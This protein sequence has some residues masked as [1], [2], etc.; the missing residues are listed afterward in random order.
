MAQEENGIPVGD[1]NVERRSINFLPR[2][3]RTTANAKFIGSTL[4]QMLQPGVVEKVDG[5]VGRK[6]SKAFVSTDNYVK[7]VSNTRQS[8]QLEPAAVVEDNV[9][10]VIMYKDYMDYM[11]STAIRNAKTIDHSITNAQEYYAWDPHINWDKFV[12]FREYYWL[13]QG[14]NPIAVYGNFREVESTITVNAIDN[15][16][17]FG[18]NFNPINP[19]SNTTLTLFRGQTYVFDI[20]TPNMPFTIRTAK[21]LDASSIYSTGVSSQKVDSGQ[22]TFEVDLEAPNYL[23]Y[24]NE[25]DIEASGL[26]IIKDILDNTVI[27]VEQEILNKKAY[28]MANGYNLSNGMKLKFYGDVSPAKYANGNWYVEGVGDSITLV[29]EADVVLTADYLIDNAIEFDGGGFSNLPFDNATSYANQKDYI[30]INKAS[31]DKNQWSRYNR[32][33]HKSVIEQ[34]AKINN[35][36][37]ELDQNFRAVRPIIEFEAGLKLYNC[38]SF[39]KQAVD[40]VD[41]VTKDVFSTIEG[42]AGYFVDQTE[43]VSGMRVLFTADPD[44]FVA[45]KIYEVKFITQN[46]NRQITLVETDD[47]APQENETV[48]VTSGAKF[49]GKLFWYNGTKWNQAQDKIKLN[50]APLFDLY[51]GDDNSLSDL[52][53]SSFVGNKIFSYKEG[54]GSNDTELAFPLSYRTIENSGDIVFDFN[55]LAD[56]YTYDDIANVITAS[57]DIGYLRKYTSRTSYASLSAWTKADKKSEQWVVGQPTVGPRT[58]NF[59]ISWYNKSGNLSDLEVRVY[60]N[61][62]RIKDF[63][64]VRNN[65]TAYVQFTENLQ[66]GSKLVIKTKSKAEKN[67]NGFYEFPI[68]LEKNPQNENVTSFT[69]GE[70]LDHVSSIVDNVNEFEGTYPGSSNLRDIGNLSKNGLRFVKHSGPINLALFNL[71]QKDYDAIK[72]IKYAGI[73]YRKF[74]REFVR[75]AGELGFDGPTKLH[76]DKVLGAVNDGKTSKDAFYFSD[77]VPVGGDKATTHVIDDAS[78]TI[79][80]LTRGIDFTKLN[81]FAVLPYLNG[82]V[83]TKDLDYTVSTNGFLELKI[84][85]KAGD[86]LVVYEYETTDGCWIPPTPTKLGLYPKYRPEVFLDDTYISVTPE[87]DGPY[88]IYGRDE[89]TTNTSYKNKLGWF[90]PLYTTEASAKAADLANGGSGQ[91]HDHLFAGYNKL[92]YM[93]SSMMNHA[94]ADDD[95]Y[96]EWPVAKPMIQGHDGSLWRCFGDYRDELI[97]DLE[98]RIFNNLKQPY[99]E[100]VLDVADFTSTK[101]RKTDFDRYKISNTMISDFNRWLET[102]GNPDYTTNTYFDRTD[103]FTFNYRSFG[104]V[105]ETPLPGFWRAVFKDIYNTDRPHSHPWE[106]LGLTIKPSWWD[107]VYGEAPYTSNNLLLWEDL[108]KGIVREPGKKVVYRNKFANEN[109]YEKI[110]VDDQGYLLNPANA[111][112][113]NFGLD[114][115]YN[116]PFVFGDEGPVETAW[117]RSSHY[118]FSLITA[119]A[120]YEPAQ[121]FGVAFDISRI[122]RDNAGQLVYT[123]TSKQIELDQIKF[124]NGASDNSRVNTAGIVNYIQGYLNDNATVRF[125]QYQTELASVNNKICAKIGGFTQKEKFR[126]ILDSRNPTNEGNVF[127]PIENYK[128][129]LNKSVPLEVYSYSGV[130]VEITGAG[131]IVKGYDRETPVFKTY[132]VMPKVSD[133]LIT[134]GGTSETFLTWTSGKFYE[135][136]Q[137]VEL[138][139][140]YYR[141]KISHT[142]ADGFDLDNFQ[143]IAELPIEGGAQA[144]LRKNFDRSAIKEVQYGTLFREIQDVVDFLLGYEQYLISVGFKFETFNKDLGEIE[145]WLLSAK[146]FMFWTTQNWEA[147]TLISL[148]PSAREIRFSKEYTVVDDIYDNFYD[149][150]L[151][152][153]DG[154]RLLADFATTERT[155]TNDFGLYVKNTDNGIFNLKIPVVQHEHVVILDNIIKHRHII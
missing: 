5:Y 60:V 33:T 2:Y 109:M 44:S 12:N 108:S 141:V 118:P 111:G 88:K 31:P 68:N 155:N 55:M 35:V 62:V 6:D 29:S 135:V 58:N 149:Y 140:D 115:S 151:L 139:D 87:S 125:K 43:L 123:E 130:I 112:V 153:T 93:P 66:T 105:D 120:L 24:V 94:V 117:R 30:C 20:N 89:T 97:L 71:T 21:N 92:F 40:L 91:A 144:Y 18:Y 3:F 116:D 114:S 96:Q 14:P 38:G 19:N 101:S 64:I 47:T 154:K 100:D 126:L 104:Y 70:V 150:S 27:N 122:A 152:G 45:G 119:R 63:S 52:D 72:A 75:L 65:G 74:K 57:T 22:I 138:N 145:N 56:T 80:S 61:N 4:D 69:L 110:P 102:V 127:V 77:M 142:S 121:F 8:Y 34:T 13:P 15:V 9:G 1:D 17:N 79:F 134:I 37:V 41:T 107:E 82:K 26:I 32:W 83:L 95:L 113:A 99:R 133:P 23:Y 106:V 136:G 129:H 137:I 85:V 53:G 50:Q 48:F 76:V 7:D 86:E 67:A 49:K 59:S 46:G 146:E 148:S 147:G 54:N 25:N 51:N 16:D 28:T 103:G 131:F 81:Q 84:D 98:R 128:I 143:K 42:Q 78:E 11:N 90:Y 73:E 132:P 39:A 124:P 10:N 36:A